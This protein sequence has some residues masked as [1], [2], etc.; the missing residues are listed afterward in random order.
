M[1]L[2]I[3]VIL[4]VTIGISIGIAQMGEDQISIVITS[5]GK[6]K[7]SQALFP[8]TFV[9]SIDVHMISNNISNMLA[10]DEENILLGTTQN[11]NLLK[12]ATLGASFVDLKYDADILSYESGVFRLKYNSE[13][14]SKVSLPP[15]SKLV[16]LNTIP[17]EI[18]EKEYILPPGDISLSFTIRPVISNEFFVN[19]DNSEQKIEAIT[20]A[21]IEEFSANQDEIQFIIKDRAIVLTIIPKQVMTD[22][23]D[24]LLN[25][26]KVDFSQFHQNS[27]HSWIRIDPHEKG[28]VKILDTNEKTEDGGG[29]LIATATFGSE[30]SQQVQFL[31]EIRDNQLMNSE[32]GISFMINFNQF[33]YSFSPHVADYQRENELFNEFVKIIITP[34]LASLHLMNYAES[35]NEIIG[36][37]ISVIVLNIGMYFVLPFVICYQGMRIL[38]TKRM[39]KSNLL[40]ISS[41]TVLSAVKKSLFG[42]I[43]LLVLTV[44]VSSAFDEAYAADEDPIRMILDITYEN[45]QDSRDNAGVISEASETFFSAG[46]EKYNEAIAALEA[47]DIVTAKESALVAMAL[48]EDAAEE[49]GAIEEQ[50]STQLP[51]GLGAGIGSASDNGISNGQGL[52]VGGIPPGILKQVTA[53]NVFEI[54]EQITDIDEEVDQ[55]LELAQSNGIDIDTQDYDESVN[56]AKEVLANGDI[57]NAQAKLALANEIKGDIINQMNEAAAE[58]EDER[59]QEFVD[60]S[61]SEIEEMLEKG[62][63]LG[64]TKKAIRELEDTLDVL[65]TGEIEDILEKTDDDSELAKELGEDNDNETPEDAPGNSGDAPGQNKE[66]APGNSGDAPGQNKEDAPG[67]SGDAPGQNKEDA[68]G[69]SGDAPGQN[70]EDDDTGLPPGFEAADDNPSENGFA[71]GNGLGLGKVPPGLAKLFGNDEVTGL[72]PGFEA[73]D[74]NPSEN[75]FANGNGLG[76]GNIP[77]G[78][79]KKLDYSEFGTYSPD[80]YFDDATEDLME[81][82]FEEKFDKMNKNSKAKEKKEKAK[83][84]KL[85]RIAAAAANGGPP[86]LAKKANDGI[87]DGESTSTCAET[88]S[89]YTVQGFTAIKNGKDFTSN[90][91]IDV[92]M[93][94]GSGLGNVNNENQPYSFTPDVAGDYIITA[95]VGGLTDVTRTVTAQASC[96]SGPP[97]ANAGPDQSVYEGPTLVTLDGTGSS[98]AGAGTVTDYAWTQTAG[99]TVSLSDDTASQPTFTPPTVGAGGET[100]TFSLIVTDNDSND[101]TADTVDIVVN[102]NTAPTVT[103][104]IADQSGSG[105]LPD[106]VIDLA[107]VFSDGEEASSALTYT[108]TGNTF[109]GSFS[110]I[111]ITGTTLTI[112]YRN[113]GPGNGSGDITITATDSG[114]L[115][116]T[117]TFN[118][119]DS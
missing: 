70:K 79:F 65:K 118:V 66:D 94:A 75:G 37:G 96:A 51:P 71:N 22:P 67:N 5:E 39:K 74:D 45:I 13:I 91:K 23:N 86:G 21:K 25:G 89:L 64:L 28:L 38:R 88:S 32:S 112:D 116:V 48:F 34:M 58:S 103:S 3:I 15:L 84:D 119:I 104:P 6:A 85:D 93:A 113:G 99:T 46:E 77:P 14:E 115:T 108:I 60:N 49:I 106:F 54:Q 19:I 56:L 102:D 69:N 97:T 101:S 90:I 100:L 81:D 31:R 2:Q 78:Q 50:A 80:D 87:T 47:G 83:Q 55:L 105:N 98:D 12:I 95:E 73:A 30:M 18:T 9:S 1:K 35:E 57:P 7:I 4:L 11:E 107:T 61:I 17:I 41:H 111:S 76:L 114:G 42:I 33:Y 27:T 92:E 63:N 109:S 59:V 8:K 44:S 53:A 72:P 82:S 52:G 68:P 43:A 26:E 10:I 110:D 20:A 62:E 117:D 40:V 36:F 29:C 24:A 16:S